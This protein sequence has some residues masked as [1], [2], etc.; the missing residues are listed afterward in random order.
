[1]RHSQIEDILPLTPLQHGFLFHAL[2]DDAVQDSYV[3][4]MTFVL[5]GALDPAA[6]R[7]AADALLRRHASLRAAFVH[8]KIKEPV[9]VIQREV[10]APWRDLDLST[11]APDAREAALAQAIADDAQERFDLTRAPLLRFVLVRAA[12]A[13]HYLIFTSH[14]ILLDGWSTPIALQEL[15]ALY[16]NGADIDALPRVA[17]YRDYMRWLGGRD[18]AAAREAWAAAFAGFQEPTRIAAASTAPAVPETLRIDLPEDLVSRLT[19]QAR[20]LG[21]TLNTLVQAAWGV[22]LGRLTHR[23]DVAFGTTV[24]GRP[25]ELAGVEQM[26]GLFINTVPLRLQWRPDETVAVLLQRLQRDQSALLDHQHLGLTEIQRIAGHG[27]LFDTLVVFENFPLGDDGDGAQDLAVAVHSHQGGDTSHYPLGLALIPGT[28]YQLKLSYRPDLLASE[29]VLRLGRRYQRLIEAFAADPQQPLGR[30]DLLDAD[31]AQRVVRDWNATAHAVPETT[32]ATLLSAQAARTPDAIALRFEGHS[33]RYAELEARSNRLARALIA[34]GIGPESIVGVALPRALELPVALCAALKSGAAYLPLD[35]DY[36]PERLAEMLADA[37]PA[38]VLTRHDVADRLPAGTPQWRLD[39]IALGKRLVALPAH[40]IDD[41]ERRAPLRSQHPAYVIYTSGSTGKPKGAAIP[42]RGVVNRLAW[43]QHAYGLRGDDAVLQKTPI[44]FDVSVWELFWPLTQGAR[45]VLARP[46]GQREPRY[47]ARLIERE[48]V[49]TVHFVASMLDM[50]VLE[51]DAWQCASL[52]RVVC[53]GEALSADLH[54]RATQRLGR[55]LHHSYGPTE[56]SIGVAAWPCREHEDGPIPIGGPIANTRFY[57][58]DAALRPVPPGTLGELYIAGAC[59]ARGYLGRAALSAERF[60]ADPFAHGERMYRSGDLAQWREDG[61]IVHRGRADHQVKVRGLRIELGEIESELARAGYPRNAVIVREDRPDQRRIVGYVAAAAGFDADALRARLAQRLPEYMVP[62]ALVALPALPQLPNGKLDRKALPAVEHAPTSQRAPRDARERALCGLYAEV[63][64]VERVGIDDSFFALGGHSLLAIRLISR[65]RAELDIELPIR[66][67]F[68][69]PGVAALAAVLNPHSARRPLLEKQQRPPRLPLSFAQR[70]LWFLHRFEGPSATYNLPLALELHGPLDLPALRAALADLVERHESLRT[71]FPDA[72]VPHQQ[73]LAPLAPPLHERVIAQSMLAGA[74]AED[75]AHA[76]D[77]ASEIPLRATLYRFD[78]QATRDS[79]EQRHALLLLLHHIACDGASM[80]PLAADLADAYAARLA[81]GSPRRAPLP[82]QYADYTLWQQRTL[83][84]DGDPSSLIGAQIG[85]W[86]ERLAGLPDC[87]VLPIDRPRPPRASYRGAQ[88]P[89]AVDAETHARL[90]ALARAH[91]ASLFMVLQA[92]L[93]A[94]LTRLGAGTDIALG[95][96]VAG[97]ND[98]ALHDLVGLF[99]N[100]LVLRNDTSGNPRF[101][102]LLARARD[103]ALAAYEHQDLPFEQLV[104]LL[105]P[106]RSLAHHPLFQVLIVLQNTARAELDLPGLRVRAAQFDHSVA[107]F[108]LSFAF[109]ERFD[110][111]GAPCGLD[112]AVE[113]ALDL[114]EPASAAAIAA[115]L[116][117]ML[118]AVARDGEAPIGSVEM[119]DPHERR[120]VLETWNAT[121]HEVAAESVAAAFARQAAATP[122]AIAV[123]GEQVAWCYAEL[124]RRADALAHALR[125]H[126]ATAERGVGIL[127]QRSP[128]LIVAVLAVLKTGAYYVPLHA[129]HPDARLSALLAQTGAQLLVADASA[130]GRSIAAAHTVRVDAFGFDVAEADDRPA[131]AIHPEQLAYVMFTSGSTGIPKGVAVRQR[132]IVALARDRRFDHGHATVLLHSSHAFDASTYEL[133]V[134]LLR[135]GRV[136]VLDADAGDARDYQRAIERHGVSALWLTAGL[137]HEFADAAPDLFAP[138]QQVLAG[139]DVLHPAAIRRLQARHPRLRIVN[140]YGPTETTTFALAGAVEPLGE[141]VSSVALGTPLDNMQVYVLDAALQPMPV[142]ATGELYIAGAGLARGYL[143]QAALSAERFVANPFAPGARMYRSGDL[144]RWRADGRID[145]LGRSDQQVKLRGLRVEL[146]EIDAALADLGHAPA[147][148][149][150]R[151]DRPGQKQLVAYLVA[152]SVDADALRERLAQRLPAYMLPAAF[153]AVPALPLTANG[154]LDRRALPAPCFAPVAARAPRNADEA[155]LCELF[156]QTLGLENVG[157]DDGFFA[158]GGDSIGSIQLVGRAR[159]RGLQFSARDVFEHKNVRALA[160]IARR[161]HAADAAPAQPPCGPL[162]ATPIQRWLFEQPG[163]HAHFAQSMLLQVPVLEAAALRAALQD[164]LDHHHALRLR[165]DAACALDIAPVGAVRAT[166]TLERI[167]LHGIGGDARAARIADATAAAQARLDPSTGQVL[168]AVW[169]DAGDDAS[170]LFLA[171]H[172]LAVDGVSWR[173]LVPDLQAAY[174]ARADGQ[175]PLLQP[176]PTSLR[177]WALALPQM[178]AARRAELPFWQTMSTADTAPLGLRALDSARDTAKRQRH[179]ALRLDSATTR[180]LLTR[181]SERIGGRVNDVLLTAFALAVA[182]WRH[183]RGRDADTVHFDLEGHGRDAAVAGAD[184]SRTVGWFTSLFPLALS[185]RG[186][187]RT[188]ALAGGDALDRALKSVKE[189]LRAL[190]D[191]GIGYGLLRYLDPEGGAVLGACAGAQMAFNYLGRFAV[192][193]PSGAD[194]AWTLAADAGLVGASQEARPLAHALA[195]NAATEDRADGPVL[196]A[197]WSWAEELFAP[198][199]IETLGQGWFAALRRIAANADAP[200]RL[201]PSDVPLS[202]LDQAEIEAVEATQPPL[203][204][205]LPLSPL[206]HGFLF[207]AQYGAAAPDAARDR[208]EADSYVVQMAFTLDGALQPAALRHAARALLRR[209][210][211]LRAAFLHQGL[212]VPVQAIVREA[213]LPW[214]DVDLPAASAPRAAALDLLLREDRA[215]GFDLQHG[216]L[217]RVTLVREH[218]LRHVLALTYHHILFDGWS[219]PVLLEEWFALYRN[220]GDDTALAPPA[221]YRDYL[222]WLAGRDQAAAERAWREALAGLDEPTLVASRRGRGDAATRVLAQALPQPLSQR[223]GERARAL[224]LTLNTLIQ[225]A[226]AVLL[227]RIVG[228]DDIVFGTTVSGRPPELPG[229]ERMLG[230]LIN[231]VPVRVRLSPRLRLDELLAG[232]QAQQSALLEHQHLGLSAI[233]RLAG[234]G[235]LFDTLTVFENYPVDARALAGADAADALRIG[236][237]SQYGGDASH[238]PLG[239]AAMPGERLRLSLSYRDDAF[240]ADRAGRLLHAYQRVLAAIAEDPAQRLGRI[241]LL[242]ATGM[243]EVAAFNRDAEDRAASATLHGMFER[244][245]ALTPHAVALIAGEQRIPYAALDARATALSARLRARGLGPGHLLAAALPRGIDAIVVLLAT[246]KSG[247]AWLPIDPDHPAERVAHALADAAPSLLVAEAGFAER[248][249]GAGIALFSLDA[250]N[251]HEQPASPA[252]AVGPYDLAYVLY[253]SGSTGRP[254]GVAVEHRQAV[255]A[256][257]ARAT[258]YPR[259]ASAVLLPSLAFDAALAPVFA[260]LASGAT[261]VLPAPGEERD[262]AALAALVRCHRVEQWIS[263][264]A[265][266]AAVLEHAG[267]G[268][269]AALASLRSVILGGENIAAAVP[270]AHAAQAPNAILHNEYGPTEATIWCASGR[271][272]HDAPTCIGTPIEGARCYVLDRALR[273]LPPGIVGELYVAGAGV[274]RG[275]LGRAAPS[276]ERFVADPFAQGE[277]MYRTGDLVRWGADGALEFHGRTDH[278]IKLRGYRIEPAEIEAALASAGYP[279]NA[280]I[281]REDAPGRRRL[282]GYVAVADG[283]FDADALRAQLAQRLPDYMVPAALLA[284]SE[285]P[286]TPNGK[287]DRDALPAPEPHADGAGRAPRTPQEAALC[288]LFAQVLGLE[289]VGADQGFFALGGDSIGSIQLVARARVQG[290]HFSVRD[291][292]EQQTAQALARVLGTGKAVADRLGALPPVA[293]SGPLPATPI[294]HWLFERPGDH[295]DFAQ[296][297]LLNVPA[298]QAE[299]LRAAVQDLIDH[300]DALRLRLLDGNALEIGA[301]GSV[302]AADLITRVDLAGGDIAATIQCI[303]EASAA[304]QRRLAPRAGRMLQMAWFDDGARSRLFLAIH[305]LAVDG[306]SWR[307]LVP[308]LRAAYEARAAGRAPVLE[309][310]PTSLRQWALAL[311]QAAAAYRDELPFWQAMDEASPAP[312]GTRALDPRRDTLASQRHLPLRLD[313]DTTRILLTRAT[314]RM[315][316]R[317][318]DVLLS[319]FALAMLQWNAERGHAEDSVHFELEGHGRDTRV[320]G[321]DLSRTVGWFT[322]QFPLRLAL[323]GVDRAAALRGDAELDRALKAIKQQLREVPNHGVGYGLLRYLDDLGRA[324]L[325]TRAPAPIGFNYLGR[326]AVGDGDAPAGWMPAADVDLGGDGDACRPLAHALSLAATTEDRS[327][328]PVLC[329]T[330]SWAGELF[331]RADIERLAA[332]WCQALRAIAARA[333]ECASLL[334]PADLALV[335]LDQAQIDALQAEAPPLLDVWPLSPLQHGFLFHSLFEQG[336]DGEAQTAERYLVQLGFTLHGPLD[337]QRLRGAA[338]ALLQR[339]PNLRAG[340]AHHGLPAPVQTIPRQAE[341]PWHELALDGDAAARKAALERFMDQDRD[342]RFDLTRG[343]A[344]RFAL[345]RDGDAC[346]HHLVFTSHHLLLDGWSSPML[347]RELFTLYREGDGALEAPA[348][349][350]DYLAW[351][352][353]RDQDAS[354]RAWREALHG[355]SEPTRLTAASNAVTVPRMLSAHVSATLAAALIAHA[356]ERQLTL[357]TLVQAAWAMVLGHLT[358]RDDVCFGVTVS[359]RPPDV[360]GVER[361]IGLFINTVPLRLRLRGQER[362]DELLDRLQAQQTALIG[363]EYLSLA[364]IQREAGGGELFDTLLVFENFPV[365]PAAAGDGGGDAA[366]LAVSLLGNHGAA[367]THYPLGLSILPPAPGEPLRLEVSYRPDLLDPGQVRRIL[368][369]FERALTAIVHTPRLRV[370]ALDLQ[371]DEERALAEA[372]NATAR[373][374]PSDTAISRFRAQAAHTPD[375]VA[376]HFGA[377]RI[378]YAELDRR[379]ER[380]ARRLQALGAG[381]D[382]IVGLCLERSPEAIVGLLGIL[383]SG[384]AYL[385]LDP[386]YPAQRLAYML[387]DARP[388]AVLTQVALRDRLPACAAQILA[389]DAIDAEPDAAPPL[390]AVP[391]PDHLA[392]VLYT[393]G[394]TGKPKAVMGTHRSLAARLHWDVA[395]DRAPIAEVYAQKTTVNFIDVLWELLMPL[396]RG[397]QLLVLTREQATDPEAMIDA[398]ARGGATRIVLVPSLLRALLDSGQA[399]A[400]RLPNLYYWA[401][402]GEAL[403]PELARRFKAQLPRARLLNVYGTSEFW[404]ATSHDVRVDERD[405]H[406]VPIG[407]LLDNVRAYVLDPFLRPVPPGTPGELY[408]AGDGLARGYLGRAAL[409]AERFVANPFERGARMYRSGD[410]VRWREEGGLDYLG[411]ADRQLKIRGQR[412]ETGEIEALLSADPGIARCA[413]GLHH[414]PS[415]RERLVAYLVPAGSGAAGLDTAA[416]RERLAA[417]LPAHMLPSAFVVLDALPLLPNGK[418]DHAALPAPDV[419]PLRPASSP[420]QQALCALFA[421]VLERDEVGVD[422]DFFELG[423]H[424]LLAPRLVARI[425]DVLGARVSVRDVFE[426]PTVA[427]LAKR[428][429]APLRALSSFEAVLP[430]RARGELAP[431]FCLPPAGGLGWWYQGLSRH[432]DPRRPIYALQGRGLRAHEPLPHS[433]EEVAEACLAQIRALQPNGPYHLLGWSYGGTLAFEVAQRMQAQ[434]DTVALLALLDSYLLTALPGFDA[435]ANRKPHARILADFLDVSGCAPDDCDAESLD[436]ERAAQLLSDSV[437]SG[438]DADQLQRLVAATA[439]DVDLLG[440]YRPGA[441]PRMD[442]VYFNATAGKQEASPGPAEFAAALDGRLHVHDLDCRHD[443]MAHPQHLARIGRVLAQRYRL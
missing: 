330:W 220:G 38:C 117:R 54:R 404:D 430:I 184:L 100:T 411:R 296:T 285:L 251:E 75:A 107:K 435:D 165:C 312:L 322:S 303:A 65:I 93:A 267:G 226:W 218:A 206:Q 209:H 405:A 281:V 72:E 172:H 389:I 188:A 238:Y 245:A 163:P 349:Y 279:R 398:L 180:I 302:P 40:A 253:T 64:G 278:Q 108:D 378:R 67:L 343:P 187:D 375:A 37:A 124:D 355:L 339:H 143:G 95:T 191:H 138:L 421:E 33:L 170:R 424:S 106:E 211:N 379:A 60:V 86:R 144:A 252:R 87:L 272:R 429:D 88:H 434:G 308:D 307:I 244:Q 323:H 45:L 403:N 115:R 1:M 164:L 196:C 236:R 126:G 310:V 319:A 248:H 127:M 29:Q 347:L 399:L 84:D 177:Q 19:W 377:R 374:Y 13:R 417:Q 53:G 228:R 134:P 311:P 412:V 304:T 298:L 227:G 324:T 210:P 222:A 282:V 284:L 142:G 214:R 58:L 265:L 128:E 112:G 194:Q 299:P 104:D 136:A 359:G 135:G 418:I 201:T 410:L 70:R 148:T 215:R 120:T 383:M 419:A 31:E 422:A 181:A 431:L 331:A 15:F 280:V 208:G 325:A 8:H 200:P 366:A 153:V 428:L 152:E 409:S 364:Q 173:I 234:I 348:P 406:G 415:A 371:A 122:D 147:A 68:E 257:R 407:T 199:D 233:Q 337:P 90:A 178:A 190:P 39:E 367:A 442:A 301:R 401:C 402:S 21:V 150:L 262:A 22:L 255:N 394:S 205:L 151:E 317:V 156:A 372:R 441:R 186:I 97:R 20:A 30:I 249:R 309:P 113:Y 103:T 384:A 321:A 146:G 204:D 260:S 139:G 344:L 80:A 42:H 305:H 356:R 300:H 35:T 219:L 335:T 261:L 12:A 400:A 247:A 396:V 240:D 157:I 89:F 43:M 169:F 185:L 94:T 338:Q 63:L 61:V 437:Y 51:A 380:V 273:P 145:F 276:A 433:L 254:K 154:K 436:Y 397:E 155:V 315:G 241:D 119:L 131:A 79:G 443:E 76:F 47:L 91:G 5:D 9:Q 316:G 110:A 314:E 192:A 440:R 141:D 4:Q 271:F 376:V 16:A 413:V 297:L 44:S 258:R 24:S 168:Q 36:P 166:D 202:G 295:D 25:P 17:P 266:Y 11:L 427:L 78:C 98:E 362:L 217:L 162:P 230:L 235:D 350:R 85:Y 432:L 387:D 340:F 386:D 213:E 326:F 118:V 287:L 140:G 259:H 23:R 41:G 62:A 26:V 328:G 292:F 83:G 18:R 2:Y 28:P 182:D 225:G 414:A 55:P 370:A 354:R 92:A 425:R 270:A 3:V 223:L 290:L 121:A 277:R 81:G 34:A 96:P 392:Y 318:N 363:H 198:A 351:L 423:G 123:V 313:G 250:D 438:F 256:I 416:L 243:I 193:A 161:E 66:A 342:R 246:L 224:G 393:S 49:T 332:L 231:T 207:H 221:P 46:E 388:M 336:G 357:N 203:Q 333:A 105:R 52:R 237:H 10:R 133:W 358:R 160:R 426:A 183:A 6:L 365:E 14:H 197:D 345:L 264:P 327:A 189:Q 102:Q 174:Q 69:A 59:L 369:R 114:F 159:Q 391:R 71:V 130:H 263:G 390:R 373:A 175:T 320:A 167:D 289:A 341:L 195:L 283:G 129:A 420:Q 176:A 171:I 360:A 408:V 288:A 361:M 381:P 82:V 291:V 353:A 216:P 382:R 268:P 286:L 346:R 32:L 179:L 239:L 73:V 116:Q 293:P 77:L 334:T 294:M 439:N 137:F 242:D 57:V 99:L 101:T 27:E 111:A 212:R 368:A 329:A 385:A 395:P 158:L 7:A 232:M 149:L 275:Y 109:N 56:T 125:R 274:A 48:R 306:V 132:D 269:G 50:F 229:V 352:H 74:L